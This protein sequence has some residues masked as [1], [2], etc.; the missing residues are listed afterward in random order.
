MEINVNFCHSTYSSTPLKF[1]SRLPK[2]FLIST[3]NHPFS[4]V[5][6]IA[7]PLSF[8]HFSHFLL[9]QFYPFSPQNQLKILVTQG[10]S[11]YTSIDSPISTCS[12]IQKPLSHQH[13][14]TFHPPSHD[15]KFSTSR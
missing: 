4:I 10:F 6:A 11:R 1:S 7:K 8:L 2:I 13:F 9:S 5:N 3:K 12:I 15:N 14:H